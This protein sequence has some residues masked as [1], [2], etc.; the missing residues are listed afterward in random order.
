MQ[1]RHFMEAR[2]DGNFFLSDGKEVTRAEARAAYRAGTLQDGVRFH[3]RVFTQG[4]GKNKNHYVFPDAEME[5]FAAS[6]VDRPLLKDHDWKQDVVGGS[7][8]ESEVVRE[9]GQVVIRQLIEAVKPWAIE[10]VLDGTMKRFSVGWDSERVMC[11]AC[12]VPIL[13][14]KCG[15]RPSDLGTI[16]KKTEKK[17]EA[18]FEN[19]EGIEVSAVVNPAAPGTGIELMQAMSEKKILAPTIPSGK[20]EEGERGTPMKWLAKLLGVPP[21]TDEAGLE[22]ALTTRLAV[23]PKEVIPVPL[24]A[25][26]G[27]K[28][29]A[30][31]D[32]A[33]AASLKLSMPGEAFVAKAKYDE[34]VLK[35]RELEADIAV[36]KLLLAG[37]LAPIHKE[38]ARNQAL[39][40]PEGFAAF[41]ASATTVTPVAVPAPSVVTTPVTTSA[42]A[43]A[44]LRSEVASRMGVTEDEMK[45]SDE[46][47]K[48]RRLAEGR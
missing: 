12:E 19:S 13:S 43:N 15:H 34:A 44:G 21:E 41:A 37:R 38:W 39:T 46:R 47:E 40:N 48:A 16:D 42:A 28:P 7:I 32:D 5:S 6:F 31:N 22:Q 1:L 4:K 24:L 8:L 18:R 23:P 33:I 3:A 30:T 35:G 36:D 20:I 27:L 10:G 25:A 9:D 14:E 29:D 45:E 17:I 26:L 11:T 2:R